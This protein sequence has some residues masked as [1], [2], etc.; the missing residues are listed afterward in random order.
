M[1]KVLAFLLLVTMLFSTVACTTTEGEPSASST[2]I[3]LGSMSASVSGSMSG[4]ASMSDSLSVGASSSV[5]GGGDEPPVTDL[6]GGQIPLVVDGVMQYEIVYENSALDQAQAFIKEL[7]RLGIKDKSGRVFDANSYAD[8]CVRDT[9]IKNNNSPDTLQIYIGTTL[10]EESK[11]AAADLRYRDSVVKKV[12]NKIVVVAGS[13]DILRTTVSNTLVLGVRKLNGNVR[14]ITEKT[15][16]ANYALQDVTIAGVELRKYTILYADGKVTLTRYGGTTT[17]TYEDYAK[18]MQARLQNSYGYVLNIKKASTTVEGANELL[19]GPTNRAISSAVTAPKEQHYSMKVQGTQVA[20]KCFGASS[21]ACLDDSFE[22]YLVRKA[23][24]NGKITVSSGTTH[25][26]LSGSIDQQHLPQ[27]AGTVRVMSYNVH[28]QL[29]GWMPE[30]SIAATVAERKETFLGLL[31]LVNADVIGFQ[32]VT[33]STGGKG[34]KA[35]AGTWAGELPAMLRSLGYE[36]L[37]ESGY[38]SKSAPSGTTTS[39][40]TLS[41]NVI[42]YKKD[43]FEP[44]NY[45]IFAY[46]RSIGAAPTHRNVGWARFKNKSTSETFV[47][48]NGHWDFADTT[49]GSRAL[50]RA[51]GTELGKKINAL[52][53]AYNCPVIAMADYNCPRDTESPDVDGYKSNQALTNLSTTGNMIDVRKLAQQGGTISTSDAMPGGTVDHIYVRQGM[54]TTCTF[55]RMLGENGVSGISDHRPLMADLKLRG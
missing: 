50:Q 24:S 49:T 44:L 52:V 11:T 39:S 5:L 42:A 19:I 46:T 36:L 33:G 23:D 53:S 1:K 22:T 7:A 38:E 41:F 32:E 27:A 10:F 34:S 3:D 20:L 28:S 14:A 37:F 35:T 26:A 21:Y 43:K 12:G 16:I 9:R 40:S 30:G 47:F 25:T 8:F 6:E 4:S 2:D 55:F 29:Q 31:Y 45:G 18:E 54:G 15:S 48:M 51:Q 17:F 13:P